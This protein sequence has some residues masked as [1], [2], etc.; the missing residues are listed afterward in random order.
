[1]QTVHALGWYFPDATGG[2]ERYVAGLA[3]ELGRLGVGA[4]ICAPI[5]GRTSQSYEHDGYSVF[6]YP[7]HPEFSAA[8]LDGSAPHGG[9]EHFEEWL[10]EQDADV[11]HLHSWT[12][13]CGRYH[14]RY[15]RALGLKTV[16]TVHLPGLTCARG[17]LLEMGRSSCD[18]KVSPARCAAC[19][20]QSHGVPRLAASLAA[21][22]LDVASARSLRRVVPTRLANV[23]A[24]P[25][26]RL[27]DIAAV[28][29]DSE[30]VVA[31][32]RW[33][34]EMLIANGIPREKISLNRHGLDDVPPKAPQQARFTPSARRVLRIVYLGRTQPVKG[35]DVLLKALQRV[36][37][38]VPVELT[39]HAVPAAFADLDYEA[40]VKRLCDGDLRVRFAGPLP[41]DRVYAALRE[42]DVIA[43]PSQW[44]ETGPLVALEALSQGLWVL[45]SRLGGL[46][47][48]VEDGATGR[49]LPHDDI[50]AWTRA[51]I[52]LA[53]E[54]F[55]P[56]PAREIR[57][58]RDVARDMHALYRDLR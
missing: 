30:H 9:F 6:R 36:P 20:L 10:K 29:L 41:P 34:Y 23:L 44:L 26:Q 51:I 54:G 17:T 32:C 12:T 39:V 42:H 50:G 3:R 55:P 2:T 21:G 14:L 43:I 5:M 25:E 58:M 49:L 16:L 22:L 40:H 11:F 37:T 57:T 56:R 18:G 45:G 8:H 53:R 47:E 28:A 24:L 31:V 46:M 1:M 4:R 48:I 19:V 35:L 38:D 52:A 13:G 7:V 33:L 27:A 15:A